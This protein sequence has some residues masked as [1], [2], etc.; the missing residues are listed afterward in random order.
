ML[1]FVFELPKVYTFPVFLDYGEQGSLDQLFE[2]E[3]GSVHYFVGFEIC[4]VLLP[5]GYSKHAIR[6]D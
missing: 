4:G 1:S 2:V 5:R 6:S 3:S